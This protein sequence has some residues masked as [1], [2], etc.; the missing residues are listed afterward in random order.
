MKGVIQPSSEPKPQQAAQPIDARRRR[1]GMKQ[2]NAAT[3]RRMSD[4]PA[5]VGTYSGRKP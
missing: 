2:A 1:A 3:A 5:K 4:T